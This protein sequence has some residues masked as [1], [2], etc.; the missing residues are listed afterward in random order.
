MAQA[1]LA[2]ELL[3]GLGAQFSGAQA[4]FFEP[5]AEVRHQTHQ[6][7]SAV[8]RVATCPQRLEDALSERPQRTTDRD[9]FLSFHNTLL[10]FDEEKSLSGR[11]NNADFGAP[12]YL[13]TPAL[14]TVSTQ[15]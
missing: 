5:C 11:P 13:R 14:N 8:L 1:K 10:S 9:T 2:E 15:L 4:T 3:D 7:I 6:L 12:S